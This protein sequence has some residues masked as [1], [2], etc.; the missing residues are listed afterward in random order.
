MHFSLLLL[1]FCYRHCFHV[2]T[3]YYILIN[4]L[5]YLLVFFPISSLSLSLSNFV[6][7]SIIFFFHFAFINL[8]RWC[9]ENMNLILLIENDLNV[10]SERDKGSKRET[11]RMLWWER[12][13]SKRKPK[14]K[15]KFLQ[16]LRFHNHTQPVKSSTAHWQLCF[17][18]VDS[19]RRIVQLG[20]V[21]E[22]NTSGRNYFNIYFIIISFKRNKTWRKRKEKRAKTMQRKQWKNE[23]IVVV[24]VFFCW[25]AQMNQVLIN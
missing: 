5:F 11:G 17:G 13:H 24:V 19:L 23:A 21:C 14:K 16:I 15:L 20:S 2:S 9:A 18:I 6:C 22:A 12:T 8:H 7:F 25:N 1:L 3:F 4:F 10:E